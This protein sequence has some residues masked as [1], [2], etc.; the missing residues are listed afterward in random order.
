MCL[1][2]CLS[3]LC[4][5]TKMYSDKTCRK[6]SKMSISLEQIKCYKPWE[7]KEIPLNR[8]INCI[9]ESANYNKPSK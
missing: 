8:K 2:V 1:S 3:V 9:T 4:R 6:N 7:Q 5:T